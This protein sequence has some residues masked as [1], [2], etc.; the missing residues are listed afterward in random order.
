VRHHGNVLRANIGERRTTK[1][2]VLVHSETSLLEFQGQARDRF[3][4][5]AS[6]R[7]C[8]Q[9]HLLSLFPETFSLSTLGLRAKK[10]PVLLLPR[11]SP[12]NGTSEGHPGV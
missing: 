10:K 8:G 9:D 2:R 5:I 11:C 6:C 12:G 7:K 3:N 1:E 4:R